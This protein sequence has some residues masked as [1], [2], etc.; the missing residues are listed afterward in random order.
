MQDGE[1]EFRV[2][3]VIPLQGPAGIF[4]PSCEAVAEL[5]AKEVN[6]RGGLQGRK[7]TIE[8]LDGGAPGDDVARTVADRLRGH[9]A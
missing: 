3:L 4:A 5:A 2:G 9:V 1:V 6:D 8:V 7:V